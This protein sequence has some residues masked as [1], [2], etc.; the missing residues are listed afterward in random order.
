[1]NEPRYWREQAA[2]R[3][4]DAGLFDYPDGDRDGNSRYRIIQAK[5]V[6]RDCPVKAECF[7]AAV[8]AHDCGVRG[9]RLLWNGRPDK[10]YTDAQSQ[11]RPPSRGLSSPRRAVAECGTRAGYMRHRDRREPVCGPC[12]VAE[13]AYQAVWRRRRRE[14]RKAAA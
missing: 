14:A 6:C 3:L 5:L 9:G 12:R 11:P 2:C 8:A 13:R 4:T 7:A 10:R 1:M